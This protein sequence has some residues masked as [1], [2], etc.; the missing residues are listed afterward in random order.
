MLSFVSRKCVWI[1]KDILCIK[2]DHMSLKETDGDSIQTHT[3]TYGHLVI[4]TF[5]HM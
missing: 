4:H 2:Y 3:S 5:I 1:K